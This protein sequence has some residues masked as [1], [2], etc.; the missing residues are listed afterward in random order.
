MQKKPDSEI[1]LQ[2]K[3][4][5][6]ISRLNLQSIKTLKVREVYSKIKDTFS[7]D[8]LEQLCNDCEWYSMGDCRKGFENLKKGGVYEK[9]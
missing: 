8:M 3:E 2:R 9:I 7:F 5:I 4:E 6:I 1:I